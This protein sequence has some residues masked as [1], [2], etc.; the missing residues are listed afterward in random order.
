MITS[1]FE[2]QEEI[3]S[4]EN[5]VGNGTLTGS[6]IALLTKRF[7]IY[8]RDK[9]GLCCE[10]VV[11]VVLVLVGLSLL[12]IPFLKDS[13]AFTLDTSAYPSPQRLLFNN[14]IISTT[15]GG[16][17][18]TPQTLAGNLPGGSYFD[19]TY[20]TTSTSYG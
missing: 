16:V 4:S 12:Q 17:D 3:G 13:P 2:K 5:L 8:K 1:S 10:I 15:A 6:I 9:C 19:V 7:H 11:P 14:D 20:D 18:F